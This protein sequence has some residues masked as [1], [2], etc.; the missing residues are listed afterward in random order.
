VV[1]QPAYEVGQAAA[2]LLLARIE[3][4]DRA[5]TTTV[6]GARLIP[7]GSSSGPRER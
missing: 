1:A 7:R 6:L 4:T 3:D 5:P 2:R